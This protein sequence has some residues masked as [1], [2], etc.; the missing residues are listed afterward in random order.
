MLLE[1]RVKNFRSIRDEQV[2][3]MVASRDTSLEDTHVARP[4]GIAQ[5]ALKSA[6]IYGPNAGGKS[7]LL[8][9][10][11]FMRTRVA[12]KQFFSVLFPD[13][14][15]ESCPFFRLDQASKNT[16][17]EFEVICTDKGVRYQYGFAL[18]RTRVVE[19]WLLVYRAD[20]P[21]EWFHRTADDKTGEDVYKF[22]SYFKGQKLTW[23]KSTRKEALFLTV[24]A[25][26]NSEQLQPIY[27]WFS[28]CCTWVSQPVFYGK[29]N[30]SALKDEES[31]R[32]IMAFIS[33]ADLGITDVVLR[34]E[35]EEAPA[36]QQGKKNGTNPREI[37]RPMFVHRTDEGANE[38]F[39]LQEES[40][41][42]QR[43]FLLAFFILRILK[44]GGVMIIDEL[45]SSL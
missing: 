39:D 10:L 43:L 11:E 21:Q 15:E 5:R 23:Q 25:G 2:L 8:Q 22:S 28:S 24:A 30:F 19:E 6:A 38:E 13:D 12:G 45:E 4:D 27:N 44:E 3:S 36:L 14:E 1:F 34:P 33:S 31:K 32:D 18:L 17:G 20:K 41:G 26:L 42:T 7:N 29:L 37:L 9:A 35:I 16:P 40:K